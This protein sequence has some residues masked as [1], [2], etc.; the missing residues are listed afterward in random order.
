ML[1]LLI[2]SLAIASAMTCIANLAT[3]IYLHRSIT[4]QAFALK[5]PAEMFFRIICWLMTNVIPYQWAAVHLQHHKATDVKGD[6]HSPI[7]EGFWKIQILNLFYYTKALKEIDIEHFGRNAPRYPWLDKYAPVGILVSA[8]SLFGIFSLIAV[9]TGISLWFAPVFAIFTLLLHAIFYNVPNATINGLCHVWGYKN[10]KEA[11]AYNVRA[12]AAI[13]FGEGLHNNHHKHPHSPV[14]RTNHRFG[15]I[16]LGWLAI[17]FLDRI[18]QIK[19]KSESW[20]I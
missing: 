13:T 18:G 2:W 8:I 17:K 10:Y 15:E 4:H 9:T 19:K 6:P 7:L 3:T 1:T 12:V 14:L 20:P 11:K 16:D 5:R